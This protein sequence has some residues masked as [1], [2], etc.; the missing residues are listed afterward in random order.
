MTRAPAPA[1]AFPHPADARAWEA[2]TRDWEA[3]CTGIFEALPASA[4][5]A[6]RAGC[7]ALRYVAI[8]LASAQALV[9]D[10]PCV[11]AI[12]IQQHAQE[13]AQGGL[14]HVPRWSFSSVPSLEDAD[15]VGEC[16]RLQERLET[17]AWHLNHDPATAPTPAMWAW[18][19]DYAPAVYVP[20]PEEGHE[21]RARA[22]ESACQAL[23]PDQRSAV[24]AWRLERA[25]ACAAAPRP[26][27]P[28][29]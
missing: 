11:L 12:D 28:R 13:T 16:E 25:C 29:L 14:V 9:R 15:P 4:S 5:P 3:V 23:P 19:R 18:W 20:N 27:R 17:L 26:P 10:H 21:G 7:E 8:V 1:G 22:W 24:Q 6:L 2:A